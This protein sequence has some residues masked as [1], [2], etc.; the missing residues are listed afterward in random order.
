ME[1]SRQECWSG[2]HFL[3]QGIFLTQGS[4]LGLQHCRQIIIWATRDSREGDHKSTRVRWITYCN[5]A[6]KQILPALIYFLLIPYASGKWIP[7]ILS[8]WDNNLFPA[9]T[10]GQSIPLARINLLPLHAPTEMCLYLYYDTKCFLPCIRIICV[11]VCAHHRVWASWRLKTV[12]F[13]LYPPQFP[14]QWHRM[15]NS[16]FHLT[17]TKHFFGAKAS[18]KIPW[19][20]GIDSE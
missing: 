14:T 7:F 19:D 2:C 11:L 18:I 17:F 16:F 20:S 1:S 8:G 12:L 5:I 4:N 9:V 3:L 13:R 10:E 15:N 6:V